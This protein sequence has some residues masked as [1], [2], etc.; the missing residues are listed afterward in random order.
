MQ[1]VEITFD[2]YAQS[3]KTKNKPDFQI[4]FYGILLLACLRQQ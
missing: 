3:Y 4:S 2:S 1:A